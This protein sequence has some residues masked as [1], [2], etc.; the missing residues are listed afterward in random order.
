[1][2][3]FLFPIPKAEKSKA[4]LV[5][6]TSSTA[7]LDRFIQIWLLTL[8]LVSSGIAGLNWLINPYGIYKASPTIGGFNQIKPEKANRDRLV[9]AAGILHQQPKH[10]IIGSSRTKQ[11]ID[12]DHSAIDVPAYNA[13]LNGISSYELRRYIEHAIATQPDLQQ[14]TVGVDFFMFNERVNIPDGPP[15]SGVAE[16]EPKGNVQSGFAEYRIGRSHLSPKD[17]FTTTFSLDAIVSSY[18]ALIASQQSPNA[19]P[20]NENGFAPRDIATDQDTKWRFKY[21]LS[22]FFAR[23][24]QFELSDDT[25][26]DFAQIVQLCKDAEIELTVFISPAHAVQWE[27]IA[28]TV[29]WNTFEQWKRELV[30]LTPV[31]DFS[32]YHSVSTEPVRSGMTYYRDNSHYRPIVGN[33]V[34]SRLFGTAHSKASIPDDFGIRLTPENVETHLASIRS[35]RR[36]WRHDN[37]TVVSWVND[38]KEQ[39]LERRSTT[40]AAVPVSKEAQRL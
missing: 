16:P 2:Q 20:A 30:A 31:W 17:I 33:W 38:I 21:D 28:Q 40:S 11:G 32:G 15:E 26:K 14:V 27:A 22:I 24:N 39:S 3:F 10:L 18:D 23:H 37:E 35:D 5:E 12:P 4:T 1:M 29:T 7:P 36:K 19:A 8:C 34:L 25:L 13:S 9:K 6:P